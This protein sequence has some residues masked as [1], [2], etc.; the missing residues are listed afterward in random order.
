M[1]ANVGV[2]PLVSNQST[3]AQLLGL[4][5]FYYELGV[6]VIESCLATRSAHDLLTSLI[7]NLSKSVG[8]GEG[9]LALH[10]MMSL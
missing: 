1:C 8:G 7:R 10:N 4:G 6:Q 3:W 9:G 5:D 2:D